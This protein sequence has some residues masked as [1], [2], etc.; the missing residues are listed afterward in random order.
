MRTATSRSSIRQGSIAIIAAS[1]T[2]MKKA[3]KELKADD[4]IR[5]LSGN[6]ARPEN[7]IER[8]TES[9]KRASEC[10]TNAGVWSHRFKSGEIA[11]MQVFS[12]RVVFQQRR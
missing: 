3:R 7:E 1:L 8:F 11:T 9:S 6:R 4:L 2:V 12:H 5:P 10:F